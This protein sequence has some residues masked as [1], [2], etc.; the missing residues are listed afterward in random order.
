[1]WGAGASARR[2]R[3]SLPRRVAPQRLAPR[4]PAPAARSRRDGGPALQRRRHGRRSGTGQP[5]P[6]RTPGRSRRDTAL[7]GARLRHH[8]HGRPARADGH[9]AALPRELAADRA[10]AP[11]RR[12]SAAHRRRRCGGAGLRAGSGRSA[13]EPDRPL[14]AT[15]PQRPSGRLRRGG[16]APARGGHRPPGGHPQHARPDLAHRRR[17]A[18]PRHLHGAVSRASS[19]PIPDRATRDRHPGAHRRRLPR[20][21]LPARHRSPATTA[22]RG[23]GADR[24]RGCSRARSRRRSRSPRGRPAPAGYPGWHTAAAPRTDP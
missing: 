6:G 10:L 14:A 8:A 22:A 20:G 2:C 3:R 4:R 16:H 9:G 24:L 13:G 12:P 7:V 23:P 18:G 1:M 11:R 17:N 15:G 19:E 21:Q 5:L